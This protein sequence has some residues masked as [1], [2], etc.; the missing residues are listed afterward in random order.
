MKTSF[1]ILQIIVSII[2]T[3]SILLQTR[4]EGMSAGGLGG[5]SQ[6][7]R[8]RRGFDSVLFRITIIFSTLFVILSLVNVLIQ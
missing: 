2:L 1:L 3:L 6:S 4:G 7:Y 5:A 8:S